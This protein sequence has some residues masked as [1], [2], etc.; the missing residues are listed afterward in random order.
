MDVFHAGCA[1]ERKS[2]ASPVTEADRASE[3]I[4]LA[5]L[6]AAFPGDPLRGRGGGCRPA[7]RQQRSARPSSWS[8]RSTAPRNSSTATPIS[9]STSR[10][11]ATACRRSA[12]SMRPARGRFFSGRPGRAEAGRTRRRRARSPAAGRSRCA[13][14]ADAADHRRQPFAPHAGDRRLHRASSRPP[15]SS[16]SARR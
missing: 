9:R 10:W 12:S 16:R 15:R 11:C 4:I 8:I 1:V 14:G 6:R 7:S 13:T 2:D 5:G 3:A